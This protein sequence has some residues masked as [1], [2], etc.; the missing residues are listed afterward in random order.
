[1]KQV[2]SSI[3][4]YFGDL[5]QT[6]NRFW[7]SPADPATLSLLRVLAG[8]MLLYTHFIWSF[9][10]PGFIGYDGYTPVEMMR[11]VPRLVAPD[12]PP[13]L[14][15]SQ[16]LDRY[17]SGEQTDAV[18]SVE[19]EITNLSL[20]PSS[21]GS[22]T[23]TDGE[24]NLPAELP[25]S[26]V[27]GRDLQLKD[28]LYVVCV[29][30]LRAI[31]SG[32]SF[33]LVVER[34]FPAPPST[35]SMWSIFFWIKS[36]WLLWTVH[37]FALLV[38]LCLFVGL[39]SRVAAVLGY[40]LAVSYVHRVTPG[41]YFGLDKTNCMIA[42]YLMLG[43]CGARYSLDRL[44]RLRK[45]TATNPEPSTS[46]NLAIRLLQVHLC[47]VYLFSGLAKMEGTTWQ[48]GTAVWWAAA[49]YEYQS[50]SLTW[51]AGW[52][53]LVAALTHATVFWETFYCCLVWNRFTKPLV[54]WMA[55]AVHGGI[56]LFMGMITFGLAMLF[57][58]LAFLKPETV[59]AWVDP[60]ASRVSL[61]LVGRKV[62]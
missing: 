52:P 41:A 47:I 6:W 40:L 34:V 17:G 61:A 45:G 37:V 46:A 2:V 43:P 35:W 56:A 1:M 5:W 59:R 23:L 18:I 10:L 14:P 8:G 50:I 12:A 62:G 3:T 57:A 28:G 4:G 7:F 31:S 49:S 44:W 33:R 54:L 26:A 25:E 38:F 24:T 39:F 36:T 42:M 27:P 58:N 53:M 30:R 19:G 55:M 29:G 51:L 32:G 20:Q 16:L 15:I 48:M 11:Q 21:G 22:F 60:V 13:P 9:D